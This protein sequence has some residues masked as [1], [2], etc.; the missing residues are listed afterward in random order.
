[1]P[2]NTH[3]M[4][5]TAALCAEIVIHVTIFGLITAHKAG[6]YE[7]L[8]YLVDL[9]VPVVIL[10]SLFFKEKYGPTAPHRIPNVVCFSAIFSLSLTGAVS[11]AIRAGSGSDFCNDFLSSHP[12][13]CR[14]A[15]WA[16]ALSWG[17]VI[18]AVAGIL[19]SFFDKHPGLAEAT[20]PSA[21]QSLREIE[22][23][24]QRYQL[25]TADSRPQIHIPRPTGPDMA[26][27]SHRAEGPL[28]PPPAYTLPRLPPRN[29]DPF[30]SLPSG[31]DGSVGRPLVLN[32]PIARA[33]GQAPRNQATFMRIEDTSPPPVRRKEQKVDARDVWKLKY[34]P[35]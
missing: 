2:F 35:L 34:I 26:S 5:R 12:E 10:A 31:Q 8:Q 25:E 19:V 1:M 24:R 9:L 18:V 22:L 3:S 15:S 32:R 29:S 20:K 27:R 23:S 6:V 28:P 7:T 13:K 33:V 4:I 30:S 16:I 21:Y 17:S 14:E 11:L